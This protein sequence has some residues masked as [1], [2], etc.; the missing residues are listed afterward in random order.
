MIRGFYS[1]YAG[2]KAMLLRQDIIASNLANAESVGF[3]QD[4]AV[5]QAYPR[6]DL[7]RIEASNRYTGAVS[8]GEVGDGRGGCLVGMVYT[9]FRQGALR[10]TGRSTD[11][12]LEGPGFF[13]VR[14]GG[15]VCYTRAGNFEL[16]A[17]GRLVTPNGLPVLGTDG[18]F[19]QAGGGELVVTEDGRVMVDGEPRGALMLV[20]FDDLDGLNKLGEGLFGGLQGRPATRTLVRQGYLESSNVDAVEQMVSMIEGFRAYESNQRLIQAQDRTLEK[21]INEVGRA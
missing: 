14:R 1:S 7:T 21:L 13:A 17:E 11:L 19:I 6:R 16:D 2:M 9:D 3:K 10:E 8:L 20:E 15:E 5:I 18:N 12:A 4:F